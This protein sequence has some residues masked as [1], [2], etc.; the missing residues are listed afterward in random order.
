MPSPATPRHTVLALL[1]VGRLAATSLGFFGCVAGVRSLVGDPDAGRA[2]AL[3]RA[4]LE[5][6]RRIV[7][8]GGNGAIGTPEDP[9]RLE[10]GAFCVLA[11]P[12]DARRTR[13]VSRAAVGVEREE[14]ESVVEQR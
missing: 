14:F 1:L 2:R 7:L 6:S 8:R 12:I 11:I 4:A 9:V 3:A 13:L 5:E 10:L